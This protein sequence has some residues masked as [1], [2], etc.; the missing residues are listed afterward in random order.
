MKKKDVLI[1]ASVVFVAAILFAASQLLD[2][3]TSK[4]PTQSIEALV[5]DMPAETNPPQTETVEPTSKPESAAAVPTLAPADAY[6]LI[7]VGD[8]IFEPYPLLEEKDIPITQIDG[9]KNT[10]HVSP[11]GFKMASATCDNQDCVNQGEV[12][13]DNRDVRLLG[14][15]V[16]CLPNT[17]MLEL[18]TPEEAAI[19]W[20]NAHESQ[21]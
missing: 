17:V 6:L 3:G 4:T 8:V 2:G 15:R 21:K 20:G 7:T 12:T 16:V 11:K 1:I 14:N 18:L 5:S 10:V 13:I 9:K 19:V